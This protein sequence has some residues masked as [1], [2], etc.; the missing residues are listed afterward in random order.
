MEDKKLYFMAL[1]FF[2]IF[3]IYDDFSPLF[4]LFLRK[5]IIFLRNFVN[6]DKK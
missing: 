4:A 3:E 2:Q 6:I 1:R 5:K